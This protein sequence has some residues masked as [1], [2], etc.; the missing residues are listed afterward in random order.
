[1]SPSD[2]KNWGEFDMGDPYF[3]TTYMREVGGKDYFESDEAFTEQPAKIIIAVLW[4]DNH[5]RL[6]GKHEDR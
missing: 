1:V 5:M 3:S 6:T 4:P 2:L